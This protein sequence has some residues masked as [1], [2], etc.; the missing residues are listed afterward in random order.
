M[1][2]HGV[3]GV[4]STP[5]GP[6]GG[7]ASWLFFPRGRESASV[8]RMWSPPLASTLRPRPG[9]V[10]FPKSVSQNNMLF[11]GVWPRPAT[12]QFA[13]GEHLTAIAYRSDF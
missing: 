8:G 3:R 1:G 2:L 5:S 7:R 13:F 4:V 9:P 11:P 6:G 12:T 10:L